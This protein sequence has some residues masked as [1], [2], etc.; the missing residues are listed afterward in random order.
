MAMT[1]D[2]LR[3]V[4]LRALAKVAP[5]AELDRLAAETPLRD[6]LD[7]DSMD[8]LAFV[9]AIHEELGID[10]PEREYP[11][12]TTLGSAVAHLSQRMR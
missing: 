10:I 4:V 12:M 2:E 6:E 9:T 3:A 1:P 8:F 11:R 5:E 7:L